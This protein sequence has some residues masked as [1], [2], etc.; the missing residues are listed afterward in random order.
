MNNYEYPVTEKRKKVWNV[1]KE[2]LVEF[3]RVCK[4]TSFK[5]LY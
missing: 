1:Q 4:K 3:D 2:L 5:I